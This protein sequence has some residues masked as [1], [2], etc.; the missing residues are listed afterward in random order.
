MAK[1]KRL[2]PAQAGYLESETPVLETKSMGLAPIAQVAGETSAAAALQELAG[3]MQRARSEGRLIQDLPEAQIEAGY[4]VRDRMLADE[5]E[6][7]V[8]M[9]SLAARGQQTPIEVVQLREGRFGLISG[10]R[11]LTALRRLLAETGE[12]KFASVQAILR[13]PA[14]AADA[15]VAMVEENE[16][17]VGL[18]YFE[19]AR[20]AAKAVE[21]GAYESEKAALLALFSTASRAKRSKIRSFLPLY[22][23]LDAHLRF[24]HMIPERLGLAM[25][26]ALQ[27]DPGWAASVQARL[28]GAAPQDA[29]AEAAL[30]ASLLAEH[31]KKQ[32]LNS[33]LETNIEPA[34]KVQAVLETVHHHPISG[35]NVVYGGTA[36]AQTLSLSGPG[37]NEAFRDRLLAWI[38]SG[39]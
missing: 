33:A 23:V 36:M 14:G 26:K 35:L 32:G 12:E 1:R 18:S 4:L 16:I 11:R 10:W 3:E 38:K 28:A 6:L 22:H 30:L 13:Q 5:D 31:G 8:L 20:V 15:Y 9:S 29:A 39:G 21:Q 25:A 24:A 7:R 34:A 17:R 27:A 2:T 19:R 37:V